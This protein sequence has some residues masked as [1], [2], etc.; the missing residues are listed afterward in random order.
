MRAEQLHA[1]GR[2]GINFDL[3][4]VSLQQQDRAELTKAGYSPSPATNEATARLALEVFDH[5]QSANRPCSLKI[6]I[7]SPLSREQADHLNSQ[8]VTVANII[9]GVT[10][11]VGSR[12]HPAVGFGSGAAIR[13]AVFKRLPT[14]HSKDVII[15]I[16]GEVSGGIGPQR[17]LRS[18][19][20]KS[21]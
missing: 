14:Y 12:A 11:T 13:A 4:I 18:V 8:R 16:E 3:I 1:S 17:S 10:A 20:I 5:M 7:S 2:H 6:A 15:G 19:I 9:A 21:N